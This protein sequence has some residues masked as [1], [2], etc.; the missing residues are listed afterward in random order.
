MRISDLKSA[1]YNPRLAL[2]PGMPDYERLARSVREFGLVQPIVWNERTGH[3]V[4]GHQ[5][6]EVLRNDGVLEV[7]AVVVSLPLDREKALNVALNN[8]QVGGDWDAGKLVDLLGELCE[9]PEFDA[10]LTGFDGEELRELLLE[11]E[12]EI[13]RDGDGDSDDGFVRVV[14]EVPEENWEAVRAE[15][16]G[17]AER[18]NVRVHVRDV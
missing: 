7:E 8:A 10:T 5:R 13:G 4:S 6:L 11:P 1:P 17:W 12:D 2:R 3:V 15:L 14:L 9:L 18:E 16:D